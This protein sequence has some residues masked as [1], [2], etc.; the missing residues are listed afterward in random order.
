MYTLVIDASGTLW[1]WG[2]N[3]NAALGRL[4][5]RDPS[6]PSDV[7]E[8]IP[9]RVEG[10]GPDGKGVDPKT[11]EVAEVTAFHATRATSTGC[12]CV[13]LSELGELRCW[14]SFRSSEGFMSV[15]STQGVSK[16][17][18]VPV[19]IPALSKYA[20]SAVAAGEHH[21]LV[22]TTDGV[23]FAWGNGEQAQLVRKILHRRKL[24][25]LNP[26]RLG[27]K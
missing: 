17:Q 4:T 16:K 14:G 27:I 19:S 24:N 25:A 6:V 18:Y 10:L 2:V 26:E 3:D 12:A 15:E 22:L 21:F 7:S 20:I 13:V 23:L 5:T 9:N 8:S 11:G 1:S